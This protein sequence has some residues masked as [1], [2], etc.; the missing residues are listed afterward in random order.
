MSRRYSTASQLVGID[1]LIP[2]ANRNDRSHRQ[3]IAATSEGSHRGYEPQSMAEQWAPTGGDGPV[4]SVV[5]R[6]GRTTCI[7]KEPVALCILAA[8]I[9]GL[10]LQRVD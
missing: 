6:L 7:E 9:S 3:S 5:T 10:N 8:S 2:T 1:T 4:A